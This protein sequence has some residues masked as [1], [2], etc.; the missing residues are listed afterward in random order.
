MAGEV[1]AAAEEGTSAKAYEYVADDFERLKRSQENVNHPPSHPPLSN[2]STRLIRLVPLTLAV[3]LKLFLQHE[4]NSYDWRRLKG[5]V[6]VGA[7]PISHFMTNPAASF[8]LRQPLL[9]SLPPAGQLRPREKYPRASHPSSQLTRW[10]CFSPLCVTPKEPAR[11]QA[12]PQ[13][14]G[15]G[16][17]AIVTVGGF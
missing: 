9:G 17:S 7:L 2:I 16:K 13:P 5:G 10:R 1:P 12:V 8:S 6:R 11:V 15:T 4:M 14:A 3:P